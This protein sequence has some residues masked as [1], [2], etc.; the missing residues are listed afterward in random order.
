MAS[1]LSVV[2]SKHGQFWKLSQYQNG[3]ASWPSSFENISFKVEFCINSSFVNSLTLGMEYIYTFTTQI[4]CS[5]D[6][7]E[8]NNNISNR[9]YNTGHH[10]MSQK[11]VC[12]ISVYF[13][14]NKLKLWLVSECAMGGKTYTFNNAHYQWLSV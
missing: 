4:K 1:V 10:F 11:H 7:I 6:I 2:Y 9:N 14:K 12:K 8:N 13:C 5:N 3:L